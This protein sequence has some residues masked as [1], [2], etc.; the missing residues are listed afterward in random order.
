MKILYPLVAALLI[1]AAVTPSA[2]QAGNSDWY[3]AYSGFGYEL[4]CQY[5]TGI[6]I[7]IE[8]V[9]PVEP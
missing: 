7:E 5:S 9:K 2:A 6:C 1:G 4:W 8:A 3:I